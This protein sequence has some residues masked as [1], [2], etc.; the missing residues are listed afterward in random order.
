MCPVFDNP[1]N[2]KILTVIL[3]LHTKIMC[4]AEIHHELCAVYSQNVMSEGTVRQW[5][6]L[7]KD[8]R[9]NE[10]MFMMKSEMVGQPS[11]VSLILF[12]VLTKKKFVKD[13]ASQFLNSCV[14]FHKFHTLFSVRLSQ[15]G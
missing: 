4:A 12:K 10:E 1:I 7:F 9:T 3:F 8:G 15:L 5:C 14:N 6:R 11:V 13:A 2:C